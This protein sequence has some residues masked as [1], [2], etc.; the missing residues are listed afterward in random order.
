MTAGSGQPRGHERR[1]ILALW[2]VLLAQGIVFALIQPVWSRVDEAQHYHYIQYLVENQA[3]PVEGETFISREVIDISVEANQW[4]WRP[5]GVLSTPTR[6]DPAEWQPVPEE[7]DEQEREKWVR[8]NLWR[9][10]YEAMQPPLYYAL[11]TPVYAAMPED[12]FIKL[13][14]MRILAALLASATLPLTWLTA[15]EACPGDRLV[16]Y[17]APVVMLL[18]QGYALNMSQVTNDALIVPLAA[19]SVL[20]LLRMVVRGLSWKRSLVAGAAIGASL[21]AKMTA[22]FLLPVAVTAL[23][24][25]VYYRRERLGNAVAHAAVI[26]AT[27]FAL[28]APLIAHNFAVYGDATGASAARPLMS[29]FFMSP[30]VSVSTLRLD[31]LLPTYWFGEPIFPFAFWTF[32]WIAVGAAMVMAILGLTWYFY[33]PE[34]GDA[35]ASAGSPDATVSRQD[36]AGAG[37]S[38]SRL[39]MNFVVAAFVIGV[40]V[41]LLIPF[42]SGIGGVPGR[43]LYPLLPLG[44]VLLIF[45]LERLLGRRAYFVCELLLVWMVVWESFNFLAYIQNR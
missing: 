4:G 1:I 18:T 25:M 23:A 44:S 15:R 30:L 35:G 28:I 32:A 27:A 9:F 7:L 41:T 42:G 17:G 2:L 13:Y 37:Q 11:N 3:L 6:L 33:R 43:Y 14:G 5:V 22:I 34:E 26:F 12:P 21:L 31:E 38:S 16:V 19:G 24:L 39:P 36:P 20:L 29:S 10:S 45:G 8:R 40:A